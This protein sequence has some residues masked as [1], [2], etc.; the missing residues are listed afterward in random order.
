MEKNNRRDFLKKATTA[1]AVAATATTIGAPA[2]VRAEKTYNWKMGDHV[3]AAFSD[4][5]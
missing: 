2:I 5:G 4:F 1:T 3:A